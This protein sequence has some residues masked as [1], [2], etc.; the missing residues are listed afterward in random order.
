M[1]DRI[2]SIAV[3]PAYNEEEGIRD[4]VLQ[5]QRHVDRVIVVDDGSE[6]STA[7]CLQDVDVTLLR[8]TGN[9]GKGAS[10]QRGFMAALE[11]E[12]HVVVT[13]D[14]DGQHRPE[15]IPLLLSMARAFPNRIIIG[16]RTRN[17]RSGAAHTAVCEPLR[18]FLDIVGRRLQ[19]KGLPV[20]FSSLSGI[21]PAFHPAL[22]GQEKQL[23]V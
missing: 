7:A 20:R 12:A 19:D 6:D 17:R 5:V 11:Y 8:N 9:M 4:L 2:S 15:D 1:A 22:A 16:A 10:L 14:A 3:I 23:C 18:R 13:L 21:A